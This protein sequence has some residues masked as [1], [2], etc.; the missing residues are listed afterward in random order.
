MT[1][2]VTVA[3]GTRSGEGNAVAIELTRLAG[4]ALGVESVTSYVELQEPLLADALGASTESTV[5]VPLLLSRGYH[6]RVDLPAALDSAGGPAVITDPLGPSTALARVQVDR[7][8]E[9]GATPGQPVVL[10]AAGS[11]DPTAADDLRAAAVLVGALWGSECRMATMAAG[12]IGE[13]VRPGDAVSV[14]LLAPG[15][16]S[17]T[18]AD[19]ARTAGAAVVSDVLGT[20]PTIVD[21]ICDRF[22]SRPDE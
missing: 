13:V 9:A 2:L 7:L 12:D 8:I 10:A 19:E 17:R 4:L 1:R 5:V 11:Q 3:H 18:L 14:Y 21:L 15:H 22:R 6:T 16:F 20:H